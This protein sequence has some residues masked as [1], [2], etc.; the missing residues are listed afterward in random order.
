MRLLTLVAAAALTACAA[1][2]PGSEGLRGGESA[3]PV[4]LSRLSPHHL[5]DSAEL[6]TW[7]DACPRVLKVFGAQMGLIDRY[8]AACTGG[9]VVI[10]VWVP[11]RT[12]SKGDDYFV[13]ANGRIDGEAYWNTISKELASVPAE[14]RASIYVES[15]NEWDY[16][17]P[18]KN[19]A[20]YN[21]FFIRFSELAAKAGFRPLVGNFSVGSIDAAAIGGCKEGLKFAVSKGGAWSY[22]AY[23]KDLSTD[24]NSESSKAWAFRYRSFLDA[25]PDLRGLPLVLTEG[26]LDEA[27]DADKSGWQAR[28]SKETYMNWL[29][30]F[31]GE[32]RKDPE[33]VGVTL[34]AIGGE[35]WKSFQLGPL[36]PA[37]VAHADASGREG[38][39][40]GPVTPGVGAGAIAEC[41]TRNG[42]ATAVGK[43]FDNGGGAAVHRWG[44]GQVQDFSGG[45]LGPNLCMLRDGEA[46]AWMVRGAIRTTYLG[47]GGA[48]GWLGYPRKDEGSLAGSPFQQF[49]NGYVTFQ[50]GAF[51]AAKGTPTAA[52]TP[53]PAVCPC[54]GVA[55]NFCQH[56][57]KTEGCPMTSPG[58][59]CDP[60]G[61]G[62]YS[63]ADWTRGWTEFKARC[64]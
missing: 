11:G 3:Q 19:P 23:T 25:H 14:K 41:Y 38:G 53:P 48:E 64:G 16:Y 42:G 52:P 58:G 37:L 44:N 63:D 31:D 46:T 40:S 22:H 60:N 28:V 7:I 35:G 12:L 30:W 20:Y 4:T 54:S 2:G 62:S 61:D 50:D 18:F 57:A 24:A 39:T 45:T 56:A 21:G 8:R 1:S 49:E 33:V 32:L 13:D 26:G 51:R 9:I 29:R 47:A 5:G 36:V 17:P 34:F 15:A 10:R 6:L 59:Y 27:G 43:P 55:D